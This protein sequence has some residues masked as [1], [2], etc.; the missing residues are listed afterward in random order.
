M[1]ICSR[2][3]RGQHS[4][5]FPRPTWLEEPTPSVELGFH[6]TF[7]EKPTAHFKTLYSLKA[8][9]GLPLFPLPWPAHSRLTRLSFRGLVAI[10]WF[11]FFFHQPGPPSI[12][13]H[14][15]WTLEAT[16][17]LRGDSLSYNTEGSGLCMLLT[18][19]QWHWGFSCSP[20]SSRKGDLNAVFP[21]RD[22]V[23]HSGLN[24]SLGK[25]YQ[26]SLSTVGQIEEEK[27]S[28]AIFL[29]QTSRSRDLQVRRPEAEAE[30][31]HWWTPQAR[32]LRGK[33]TCIFFSFC[34]LFIF[35]PSCAMLCFVLVCNRLMPGHS[36]LSQCTTI[37]VPTSFLPTSAS[38]FLPNLPPTISLGITAQTS[39]WPLQTPPSCAC[40]PHPADCSWFA[41]W[42][43][44]CGSLC[45]LSQTVN[46]MNL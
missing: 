16:A 2:S 17:E 24:G 37:Q 29:T 15:L 9:T 31:T 33:S 25:W 32:Q 13:S 8:A 30:S 39:C 11:I 21:A 44:V 4:S 40:L 26:K 46:S 41:L 45:L 19:P 18:H 5:S 22:C 42:F 28:P 14:S 1:L 12:F 7:F 10:L 3:H 35:F 27:M 43:S 36:L 6:R 20:H 23:I 34:F 38:I